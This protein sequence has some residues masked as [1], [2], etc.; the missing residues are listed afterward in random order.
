[1]KDFFTIESH[2]ADLQINIYASTLPE[3]FE[4]S[5]IAM[6]QSIKPEA[7]GCKIVDELLICEKLP[8][9]QVVDVTAHNVELLLVD[10]LSQAL[11]LS[12][13]YNEA[14]LSAEVH[15]FSDTQVQATLKGVSVN[16]FG[17]EIKAVT[18]HNLSIVQRDGKWQATIVFDI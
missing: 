6:F 10:F 15:K 1:M 8:N 7:P 16:R 4:H 18:Y 14:Y 17:T 2:T 5:V 13:V 12:D 11:Y 9:T 3:L